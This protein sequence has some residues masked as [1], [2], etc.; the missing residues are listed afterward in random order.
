MRNPD[1]IYF[2]NFAGNPEFESNY[3]YDDLSDFDF[4]GN[5]NHLQVDADFDDL[6]DFD[7]DCG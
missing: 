5:S 1:R 3:E 7:W 2:S 6:D 4:D